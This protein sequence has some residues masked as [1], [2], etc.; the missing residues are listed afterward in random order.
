MAC[1]KLCAAKSTERQ[2]VPGDRSVEHING[3]EPYSTGFP[4][5]M[6]S[7]STPR[8]MRP[9]GEGDDEALEVY[10]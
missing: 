3:D 9:E 2:E 4:G 10:R 5:R 6:K 7:S 8:P 1:R